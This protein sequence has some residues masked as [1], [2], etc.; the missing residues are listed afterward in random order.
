MAAPV[1]NTFDQPSLEG[2]MSLG[3]GKSSP[4]ISINL[5]QYLPQQAVKTL[6]STSFTLRN[7]CIATEDLYYK[8]KLER[9]LQNAPDILPMA[10]AYFEENYPGRP[11]SHKEL[12]KICYDLLLEL[13]S[14]NI[15]SQDLA[16]FLEEYSI[17][18][19]SKMI[20]CLIVNQKT[21][22]FR[23]DCSHNS[24]IKMLSYSFL[25]G[26]SPNNYETTEE[27]LH[28]LVGHIEKNN[29]FYLVLSR[30]CREFPTKMQKFINKYILG[31]KKDLFNNNEKFFSHFSF[32]HMYID[33]IIERLKFLKECF[34]N[35]PIARTMVEIKKE[36]NCFE[37]YAYVL[38]DLNEH[39]KIPEILNLAPFSMTKHEIVGLA[40]MEY[41]SMGKLEELEKLFPGVDFHDLIERYQTQKEDIALRHQCNGYY[42]MGKINQALE[43]LFKMRDP[44]QMDLTLIIN[45]PNTPEM[46]EEIRDL[47]WYLQTIPQ[48]DDPQISSYEEW[49][50]LYRRTKSQLPQRVV[51]YCLLA[52]AIAALAFLGLYFTKRWN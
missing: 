20:D 38:L 11:V 50:K 18:N 22:L 30:S 49:N 28:A 32:S 2:I 29:L 40:A 10:K 27:F 19:I 8:D 44:I 47:K 16:R 24:W 31:L 34:N 13:C 48:P 12:F 9:A 21:T 4:N 7:S 3:L 41:I 17:E 23:C 36:R 25:N 1:R 37:E 42:R 26:I 35:N 51:T 45:K 39:E 46:A 14:H 33:Q 43:C 52:C 5:L 6:K 15:S